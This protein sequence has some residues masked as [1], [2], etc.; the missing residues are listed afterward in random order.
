MGLSERPP[1]K[2]VKVCTNPCYFY[3]SA[4]ERDTLETSLLVR[5]D[6]D[7]GSSSVRL[8]DTD[9]CEQDMDLLT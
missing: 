7:D 1:G 6:R 8:N 3:T 9:E 2:S 4:L 5:L